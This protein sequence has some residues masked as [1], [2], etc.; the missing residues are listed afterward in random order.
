MR[1]LCQATDIKEALVGRQ[2]NV[3]FYLFYFVIFSFCR[4]MIMRSHKI[5]EKSKNRM[6]N[7]KKNSTPWRKNLLAFNASK[8]SSWAFN[9][10]SGTILGV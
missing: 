8:A 4:L 3:I 6:K 2:P 9:A 10:Q 7:R 1:V 5:N